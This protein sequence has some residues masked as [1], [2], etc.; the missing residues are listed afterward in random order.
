[1]S[2]RVA[3]IASIMLAYIAMI[4]TVRSQIPPSPK[5]LV[6]EVLVYSQAFT[7]IPALVQSWI[8]DGQKDF[9]MTWSESAYLIV[10]VFVSVVTFLLVIGKTIYFCWK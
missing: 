9:K 5:I 3:A 6:V 1:M 8:I 2:D 7:T 4:P 10:A